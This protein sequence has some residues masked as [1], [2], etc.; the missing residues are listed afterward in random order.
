MKRVITALILVPLTVAVV[1]F[2]PPLA[3]AAAAAAVGCVSFREYERLAAAHGVAPPQG[4]GYAAGLAVLALPV[5][6]WPLLALLAPAALACA[7]RRR[8]L[9]KALPSA[10]AVALGV[11]WIFGAWRCGL[12][13]RGIN[14]HWLLF[15]LVV[16]WVGDTAAYYAGRGFGKRKLAP[17]ISPH[18]TWEGAIASVI[19]A[20]AAAWAY[21]QLVWLAWPPGLALLLG[22][23][24]NVTAQLGDLAESAV[25][26]GARVK[27]SGTS[28]PGHGGW[29]D[30]TDGLLFSIP[31]VLAVLLL[32]KVA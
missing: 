16:N 15:A 4:L 31:A 5:A 8:P 19:A 1:L 11:L 29:L 2:A 25:K 9:S 20:L 18:K 24:C 12:A 21:S 23:I 13:L 22:S 14:P 10:A 28:L 30:R 17:E 27:D 6:G 32:L 7:M 26:R 3:F